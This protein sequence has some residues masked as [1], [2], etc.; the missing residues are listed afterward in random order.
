[1][2]G[3]DYSVEHDSRAKLD[4]PKI[5]LWGAQRRAV[6]RRREGGTRLE[7]PASGHL[8]EGGIESLGCAG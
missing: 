2:T 1:M 5:A 4:V 8:T 3:P 6:P 7:C